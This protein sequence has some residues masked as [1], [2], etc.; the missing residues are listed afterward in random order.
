MPH[1][2]YAQLGFPGA[3]DL[4]NMLQYYCELNDVFRSQQMSVQETP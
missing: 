3:E 2:V 1:A 4:A